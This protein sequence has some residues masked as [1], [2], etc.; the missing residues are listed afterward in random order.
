MDPARATA[1]GLTSTVTFPR[2]NL[3]PGRLGHQE[4]RHRSQRGRCRRRL[5]Q[6]AAR[7]ACSAPKPPPSPPSRATAGS[8]QPGDV[9]VLICRGPM[10]SGM[11]ETY[12]ITSALK[13]LDF[14]KHV[15]VLTDAR[16]SGVST[17]ACIGHISPEALAGG[18]IG[19]VLD[20]DVIE[21]VDR[22]RATLEGSVNLV[23]A[24]RAMCS[25]RR[26]ERA[27][28]PARPMRP[29]LAPDP[30]A[31][32]RY[33]AV[34]GAAA[35]QRRHLGRLRVR[36]GRDRRDPWPPDRP[37]KQAGASSPAALAR[38]SAACRRSEARDLCFNE[39]MAVNL[40]TCFPLVL[41]AALMPA[42]LQAQAPVGE[43]FAGDASVRGSVV[44]A[45]SGTSVLGGSQVSAGQSAATLKLNAAANFASVPAP[46]S[47]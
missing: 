33:P 7:R 24:R 35:G 5:S 47:A 8:R 17:G 19:K 26:R 28:W 31:A 22:P 30:R 38:A 2:G 10:G 36:C 20:G 40:R 41:V 39:E 18:P 27:C 3:A 13:Y 12:Q 46:A 9:I 6:D 25:A 15:A 4:H 34:G 37:L 11:E 43:L 45:S 42:A 23:G 21:I 1:R 14:G 32:R 44:L 29:D 16:F